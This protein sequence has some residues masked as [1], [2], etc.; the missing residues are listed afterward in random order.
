MRSSDGAESIEQRTELKS[1]EMSPF[2]AR[3]TFIQKKGSL[4][5]KG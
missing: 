1:S 3:I 5:S 2:A 4:V